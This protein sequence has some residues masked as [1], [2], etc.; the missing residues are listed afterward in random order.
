MNLEGLNLQGL[1]QEGLNLEGVNQEGFLGVAELAGT[2]K[3]AQ[4][5]GG[6]ERAGVT[7]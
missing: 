3:G 1:L 6:A 4:P 5:A 2:C 7:P